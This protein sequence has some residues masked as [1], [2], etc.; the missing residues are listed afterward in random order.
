V[1]ARVNPDIE[2]E[3]FLY[4]AWKRY[5]FPFLSSNEVQKIFLKTKAKKNPDYR[6]IR[7]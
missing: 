5:C 7:V 2:N 4:I 6:V 1:F 3:R